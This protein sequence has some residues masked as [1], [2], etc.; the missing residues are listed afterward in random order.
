[1]PIRIPKLSRTEEEEY[2]KCLQ[3]MQAEGID[4][5]VPERWLQQAGPLDIFI[6]GG[7][8]TF[9]FDLPGGGAAFAIWVRLVA[10]GPVTV[11]D[12]AMTTAW[13]DQIVLQAFFDERTPLWRLGQVDY[14]RSQV[15]NMRIMESLHFDYDCTVEGVILFVGLHPMPEASYHGMTVPF[16]LVFL[17][18]NENE[19]RIEAE[20]FVDRTWKRK[21]TNVSPKSSLYDSV[22]IPETREA[23]VSQDSAVPTA[24]DPDAQ[25]PGGQEGN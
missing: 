3:Q 18:Q 1:M 4:V 24:P 9:I 22:E 12:C 13:D 6:A 10:R 14:P 20:L 11:F 21:P 19:I 7:P 5:E 17:D 15:L 23:I 16:T 8:A 2:R 25:K